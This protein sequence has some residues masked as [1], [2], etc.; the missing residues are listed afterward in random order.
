MQQTL[1]FI[2]WVLLFPSASLAR[3]AILQSHIRLV[4]RYER[5]C[6]YA[7]AQEFAIDLGGVYGKHPGDT[8]AIRFCSKDPLPVALSTSAAD[9]R[10][11]ISILEGSYDYTSDRVVFLRSE[12]CLSSNRAV[13]ATE[14]WIIPKGAAPPSSLESMK[15]SQVRIDPL[16]MLGLIGSARNYKAA[17]QKL[18]TKLRAN[19]EAVAVSCWLLLQPT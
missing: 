11:V 3:Q 19:P 5:T 7:C 14:F 13:T 4:H 18:Q 15:S 6:G 12:N 9:Y 8:V 1:V 17:L 2:L 16:G 10:Y